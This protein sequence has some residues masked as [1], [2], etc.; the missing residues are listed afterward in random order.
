MS[1]QPP[2]VMNVLCFGGYHLPEV[3]CTLRR[4]TNIRQVS[5]L[6][7]LFLWLSWSCKSEAGEVA[8][9]ADCKCV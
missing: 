9:N 1:E 4:S 5:S 2:K 7:A 6:L 3:P 8:N